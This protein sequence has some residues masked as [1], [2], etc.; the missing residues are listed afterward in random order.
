MAEWYLTKPF[1]DVPK[2][3][4]STVEQRLAGN[5]AKPENQWDLGSIVRELDPTY[6]IPRGIDTLSN[7][8]YGAL[9]DMLLGKYQISKN[10]RQD[11]ERAGQAA[12]GT[13]E[14]V[15]DVSPLALGVKPAIKAAKTL[16]PEMAMM[17]ERYSL[18]PNMYVV[19][20]E[21]NLNFRPALEAEKIKGPEKQ[22][23]GD[24]LRQMQNKPG[25]KKEALAEIR[26][27]IVAEQGS[28]NKVMTKQE[29]EQFVEPSKYDKVDLRNA[30]QDDIEHY[31]QEAEAQL[32]PGE[33]AQHLGVPSYYTND[34]L[35]LSYGDI[36]F[37]ELDPDSQRILGRVF[38]IDESMDPDDIRNTVEDS[39]T[40]AYHE[41]L[42]DRAATLRYMA[43]ADDA[44]GPYAY[45]NVQR[46]VGSE[47]EGYF[48]FG[49]THPDYQ[50]SYRHYDEAP[51]GTIGHVR[52][53]IVSRPASIAGNV[54]VPPNSYVIEE[55][56]SDAQQT[57]AQ[58]GPLRQVHGV[59]FKSA[60]QDAIE[61]GA[62]R[63]YLPTSEAI[64][65][66]LTND[67]GE[68]SRELYQRIY[69]QEIIKEGLEPLSKIPGVKITPIKITEPP[70]RGLRPGY[71]PT[72]YDTP[73]DA[74][75]VTMQQLGVPDEIRDEMHVMTIFK[76]RAMSDKAAGWL[77][78]KNL[79]AEQFNRTYHD[80]NK[81]NL[82]DLRAKYEALLDQEI[83]DNTIDIPERTVHVYNVIELSP[84][85]REYI[86]KGPG[87]Q[88]PGY[89]AGG[90]VAGQATPGLGMAA[91]G[92]V[93]FDKGGKADKEEVPEN[94]G[95][96]REPQ[97][98]EL[99]F[100]SA[101]PDVGAMMTEDGQV[102]VNPN[103]KFT[104]DERNAIIRN[105]R[106]RLLIKYGVMSPP[107]FDLTN[108]QEEFL[109]SND[110]AKASP[111]DRRATIAAR[112]LTGDKS[113]Q[114]FTQEQQD[115][116]NMLNKTLKTYGFAKGG[117]VDKEEYSMP[118]KINRYVRQSQFKAAD[119]VGLGPEVD[120]ATTIPERYY[121][122]DEQHMGRGDAMRHLLL[123]AQLYK[124]YGE[125]P[126][127][128]IGFLHEMLGGGQTDA[129]EAMD[130]YNDILGREIGKAS[131]DRYDMVKRAMEAIESKKARVMTEAEK[132][133]SGYAKGGLV[134]ND[135]L[136][137][138]L[139]E[140]LF[141]VK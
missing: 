76:P 103:S 17:A 51:K 114:G 33:A 93:G 134:Y 29:F 137:N 2:R 40:T 15:A 125:L 4:L 106:A 78:S 66:P 42:Y 48:E 109:N 34:A 53:T 1:V 97:K 54:E 20:P 3:Q 102:I 35:M 50:D 110:Y 23:A 87:Q 72:F 47:P 57:K 26:D 138:Q 95:K 70:T 119:L 58:K 113:A 130:E 133:E 25:M 13:M 18:D 56:Q 105:E 101:R 132:R 11:L 10:P 79:T 86:L 115:Y 83:L 118:E 80:I 123:Q 65:R 117:K 52:G 71:K 112:I 131:K 73:N 75:K 14:G 104:D 44:T 88:T 74:R 108:E 90:L 6:T 31:M 116:V 67:R 19:P 129:E 16:A 5:Y 63:V 45:E 141:G 60:I 22:R 77:R 135:D 82:A 96:V 100:F 128:T 28:T 120:F 49:V 126:A 8:D 7:V 127:K 9:R 69:D 81:N 61:K 59:L 85:A 107:S 84:E 99:K 38:G 27:K 55:I 24:V 46:L 91:G 94:L 140:D 12:L 62:D 32:D 21:G 64:S 68:I 124:K 36:E 92:I 111:Q 30:A 98:E 136:I 89:A 43:G 122:A 139:A 121:P 41:I 39:I 37:H